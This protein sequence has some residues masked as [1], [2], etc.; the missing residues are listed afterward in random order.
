MRGLKMLC[1]AVL[2]TGAMMMVGCDSNGKPFWDKDYNNNNHANG[3]YGNDSNTMQGGTSSNM[4]SGSGYTG[5]TG[6][7]S[8]TGGTNANR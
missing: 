6:E 4:N 1:C 5:G 3:L 2:A 8:G 7:N